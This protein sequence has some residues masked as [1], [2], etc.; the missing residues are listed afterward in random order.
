M[1]QKNQRRKKF[2]LF[3]NDQIFTKISTVKMTRYS[4]KILTREKLKT[5]C[6]TKKLS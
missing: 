1:S 2:Q 3:Q 4:Q 5:I 6:L